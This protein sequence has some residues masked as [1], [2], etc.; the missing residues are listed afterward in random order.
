MSSFFWY[1]AVRLLGALLSAGLLWGIFASAMRRKGTPGPLALLI[2]AGA[3]WY[4]GE[5]LRVL[6]EL[7]VPGSVWAVYVTDLAWL[8]LSFLPFAILTSVLMFV[9]EEE[10]PLAV[11]L[12]DRLFW[13]T[14][15]VGCTIFLLGWCSIPNG[16]LVFSLYAIVLLAASAYLCARL[17]RRPPSQAHRLFYALISL[18]LAGIAVLWGVVYPLG[19]VHRVGVGPVMALVLFLTPIVPA[20]VLGYF[21][22]RFSFFR[23]VVN[24]AL[25]YSA[26]TGIVLT[27]YL[28]FVR[29]VAN[30][31]GQFEAGIRTEIVEAV[32]ISL[33]VFLFQPVKNRLQR[34]INRLFFQ[35]RY[36]YQHLLRE[37]SQAL[38]VPLA[39]EDRLKSVVDAVGAMLKTHQVTLVLFERVGGHLRDV[40]AIGSGGLEGFPPEEPVFGRGD[41][42]LADLEQVVGWLAVHRRFLERGELHRSLVTEALVSRGIQLCIP[43]LYEGEL[44]GILCLGKKNRTVPFS[45]EEM[46]LLETLCNQVGLAVENAKLIE[47][48][49]QLER[50]MYEAERLSSLG[51]LSA[52]I[53]HEVKNPL[54][55]IKAITTVLREEVREDE[56]KVEDLSIVLGEIDRLSRVVD[57]LLRFAR[58]GDVEVVQDVV[59]KAVLDDLGLILAHEAQRHGAEVVIECDPGLTVAGNLEDLKEI[60]FNLIL[61]GIQAMEG[62]TSGEAARLT[63]SARCE[64]RGFVEVAVQDTGPGIPDVAMEHLFEPFYTTKVTG[65]GLGLAIVKRD[66]ER[67]GGTVFVR[68]DGAGT[69]FLVRLRGGNDA[70]EDS[71]CG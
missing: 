31:F 11:R 65:T 37:L 35:A 56:A 14:F 54:S 9:P 16:R 47:R 71:D 10:L 6:I 22:Y 38:N 23:I 62:S 27:V 58:P 4:S 44:V 64:E 12:K 61:N 67:M 45:T 51:M 40:R 26:L 32:L 50:Q 34:G 7:A 69:T 30:A 68:S 1:D 60:F 15:L 25:L 52:S 48:R 66:V 36:E 19:L 41:V 2:C 17:M 5:A 43:V 57:R 21:I 63:I 59:L 53:A 20:F 33:L 3:V 70:G 29:R 18:S 28:L 42:D 8:G 46:E 39:I 24:P 55:S 13:P 49:L